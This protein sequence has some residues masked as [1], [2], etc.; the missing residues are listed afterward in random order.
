ME[1]FPHVSTWRHSVVNTW[2]EGEIT[3]IEGR[4]VFVQ[5]NGTEWE[6]AGPVRYR[7]WQLDPVIE[8]QNFKVLD[9]DDILEN[10]HFDVEDYYAT[11][12]GI[13]PEVEWKEAA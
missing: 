8:G 9:D 6:K 13:Y 12:Y 3:K 7:D 10:P 4:D 11:E 1:A 2:I 5:W